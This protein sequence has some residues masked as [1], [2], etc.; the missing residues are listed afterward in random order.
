MDL[1]WK[2]TQKMKSG[3]EAIGYDTGPKGQS[4]IHTGYSAT[5]SE[6]KLDAVLASFKKCGQVLGVIS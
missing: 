2:I 3:F 5:H 1:L 6:D 4:L